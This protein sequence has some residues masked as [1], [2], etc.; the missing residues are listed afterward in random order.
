MNLAT[1]ST[2][3]YIEIDLPEVGSARY[4]TSIGIASW[5]LIE[6]ECVTLARSIL[7]SSINVPWI[8]VVYGCSC[9]ENVL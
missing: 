2:S 7:S 8:M 9:S 5:K 6:F 3:F 4:A 1:L